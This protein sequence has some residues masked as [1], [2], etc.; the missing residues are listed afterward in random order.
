[1]KYCS[2][3]TQDKH[4]IG[5]RLCYVIFALLPYILSL[6]GNSYK[7]LKNSASLSF[8]KA[9][10]VC[11]HSRVLIGSFNSYSSHTDGHDTDWLF[12]CLCDDGCVWICVELRSIC[13]LLMLFTYTQLSGWH[14]FSSF[15]FSFIVFSTLKSCHIST[16]SLSH[17]HQTKTNST[18]QQH[19]TFILKRSWCYTQNIFRNKINETLT[20]LWFKLW[21]SKLSPINTVT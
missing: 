12:K 4:E 1:M 8:S 15:M 2:I 21:P 7:F 6:K 19:S 11:R 17:S 13:Y 10:H 16:H 20:S 18:C 3:G 9:D 14:F 5:M